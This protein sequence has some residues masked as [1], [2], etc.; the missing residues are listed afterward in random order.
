MFSQKSA[1]SG[2]L[3]YSRDHKSWSTWYG[4]SWGSHSG[5]AMHTYDSDAEPLPQTTIDGWKQGEYGD[6]VLPGSEMQYRK[7]NMGP[8]DHHRRGTGDHQAGAVWSYHTGLKDIGLLKHTHGGVYMQQYGLNPISDTTNPFYPT[9]KHGSAGDEANPETR[10]PSSRVYLVHNGDT[11][12]REGG[13]RQCGDDWILALNTEKGGNVCAIVDKR[14]NIK[15][16]KTIE[17]STGGWRGGEMM[18][19]A[20]LGQPVATTCG[21]QGRFLFGYAQ[22]GESRWVVE[23]DGNC[24]A[25]E[26]TRKEVGAHTTWPI[27]QDWVTTSEGAVVWVTAWNIGQNGELSMYMRPKACTYPNADEDGYMCAASSPNPT[28]Q[29]KVTVYHP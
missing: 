27:K 4:A 9:G 14:G 29:A 8:T 28:N 10:P 21:A 22:R 5:Y 7:E 17:G 19:V 26:S 6:L 24:D 11:A 25:K 16:W 13:L 12:K 3:I 1:G 20:P 18:R 23:V 15:K 2:Y